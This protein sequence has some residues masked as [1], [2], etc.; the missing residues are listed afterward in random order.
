MFESFLNWLNKTAN[1]LIK[2]FM[3]VGHQEYLRKY[4]TYVCTIKFYAY[5]VIYAL[6]ITFPKY[7]TVIALLYAN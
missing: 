1:S 3:Y 6:L 4:I 2:V 7:V 5:K